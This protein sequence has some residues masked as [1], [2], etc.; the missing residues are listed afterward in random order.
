MGFTRLAGFAA[1]GFVAIVL[2]LNAVLEST[3]PPG[4]D[5]A[6]AEVARYFTEHADL[7]RTG[8]LLAAIAWLCITVFAAG[9]LARQPGEPWAMVGLAGVV[10]QTVLFAAVCAT[11]LALTGPA[12]GDASTSVLWHLHN[13]LW[14]TN[15]VGLVLTLTG[16]SLGGLRSANPTAMARVDGSDQRRAP[17]RRHGRR[18]LQRGRRRAGRAL[19]DRPRRLAAL[20]VLAGH[21]RRGPGAWREPGHRE[22]ARPG[23]GPMSAT[24]VE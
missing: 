15:S 5:A 4:G 11:R 21:L 18:R 7:V 6:A 24:A 23:A 22:G 8:V 16:F 3:K 9:A 14:V 2:S 20:G 17:A 19:G 13:T 12:G 1:F 10:I